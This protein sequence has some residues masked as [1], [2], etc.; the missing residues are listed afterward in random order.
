LEET[1][2]TSTYSGVA[3]NIAYTLT[4]NADNT[5]KSQDGYDANLTTE[6]IS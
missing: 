1:N 4:F 3:E 2:Y 6:G 5:F